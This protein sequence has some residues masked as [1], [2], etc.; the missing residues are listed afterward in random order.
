MTITS[1]AEL[2]K[3]EYL[4]LLRLNMRE[5][6]TM[7]ETLKECREQ[8]CGHVAY[9]EDEGKIVAWCLYYKTVGGTGAHFYTK[10]SHRRRGLGT[11]LAEYVKSVA[12]DIEVSKGTENK[13]FFEKVG[14]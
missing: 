4:Q 5:A 1:P 14:I 3:D 12:E 10:K 7:R 6:G 11:K 8:K 2:N 13:D 9:I